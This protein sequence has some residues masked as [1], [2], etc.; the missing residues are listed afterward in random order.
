MVLS[1]PRTSPGPRQTPDIAISQVHLHAEQ[2]LRQEHAQLQYE[3][4]TL[5][6]EHARQGEWRQSMVGLEE[7]AENALKNA[8]GRLAAE[9]M[10]YEAEHASQRDF[11]VGAEARLRTE[12]VEQ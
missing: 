6:K 2:I 7:Q 12:Q 10:N 5:S 8:K 9:V 1:R 3:H 11:L 4:E